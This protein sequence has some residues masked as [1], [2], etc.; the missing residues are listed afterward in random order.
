MA[1]PDVIAVGAAD[2]PVAACLAEKPALSILVLE[3]GK[4][5]GLQQRCHR[6]CSTAGGWPAWCMTGTTAQQHDD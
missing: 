6:T 5:H 1:I 3:A 4:D 2:G